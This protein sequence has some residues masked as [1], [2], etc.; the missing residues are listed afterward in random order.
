MNRKPLIQRVAQALMLAAALSMAA[1]PTFA[2]DVSSGQT[3]GGNC[4]IWQLIRSTQTG[5]YC[6]YL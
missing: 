4:S 5:V 3:G 1:P 6:G 2:R